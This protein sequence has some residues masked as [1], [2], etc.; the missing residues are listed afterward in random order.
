MLPCQLVRTRGLRFQGLSGITTHLHAD[1]S[2]QCPLSEQLQ[3][4]L[5]DWSCQHRACTG[6]LCG[7]CRRQHLTLAAL[8]PC[9][10]CMHVRTPL[11]LIIIIRFLHFYASPWNFACASAPSLCVSVRTC[12]CPCA[13]AD[14]VIRGLG[15][16]GSH[17]CAYGRGGG[18]VRPRPRGH[19]APRPQEVELTA[20]AHHVPSLQ[21]VLNQFSLIGCTCLYGLSQGQFSMLHHSICCTPHCSWCRITALTS[22]RTG[23]IFRASDR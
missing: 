13:S 22:S 20:G 1:E 15:R 11:N 5:A 8:L 23:L 9:L 12:A 21:L 2:M 6:F 16:P 3:N 7:R 18:P 19:P 14:A 4:R 17:G 10:R